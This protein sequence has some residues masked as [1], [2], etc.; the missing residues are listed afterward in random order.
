MIDQMLA[1][2]W[3]NREKAGL[4]NVEFLKGVIEAVPL[5]DDHADVVISNCVINL[6]SE[7][8]KVIGEAYRVLKPGGRFAVSDVVFFL[9]DKARLPADVARSVEMWTGCVSGALEKSEY[10]AMLEGAGFEGISIEVTHTYPPDQ[11]AVSLGPEGVETLR[12]VP[13]ASAFVRA[14]K[15]T[16]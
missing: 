12:E 14:M 6:S 13:V 3:E 9:G 5:P 4:E 15:P 7:K 10:E 16:S 8:E 2:A 1:L 11:M